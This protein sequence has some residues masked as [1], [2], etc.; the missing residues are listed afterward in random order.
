MSLAK[1]EKACI[2]LFQE[3]LI[4][5]DRSLFHDRAVLRRPLGLPL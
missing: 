5:T 3:S 2:W 1:I 4:T